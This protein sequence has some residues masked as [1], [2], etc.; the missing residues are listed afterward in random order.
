MEETDRLQKEAEQWKDFILKYESLTRS[1]VEEDSTPSTNGHTA[2]G[3]KV[4]RDSLAGHCVRLILENGPLTL[5]SLAE[6]LEA[7]GHGQGFKDF[8]TAVNTALWRRRQD[9]F[10]KR[11][12]DYH[13]RTEEIEFV[14]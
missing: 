5:K 3:V 8:A 4:K 9:L 1:V 7:M 13:L 12:K 14:D 11:E 2:E 10:E 6:R